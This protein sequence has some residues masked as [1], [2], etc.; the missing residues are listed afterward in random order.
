MKNLYV[1]IRIGNA[2]ALLKPLF[3]LLLIEILVFSIFALIP[4]GHDVYVYLLEEGFWTNGI[5]ILLLFVS[6]V[7]LSCSSGLGA[8]VILSLSKI[9][10]QYITENSTIQNKIDYGKARNWV[11]T[12]LWYFPYLSFLLGLYKA[13]GFQKEN[14][15][16][17]FGYTAIFLTLLFTGMGFWLIFRARK[18]IWTYVRERLARIHGTDGASELMKKFRGSENISLKDFRPLIIVLCVLL[19]FSVLLF[20][21]FAILPSNFYYFIGAAALVVFGL[22]AW[23]NLY[24]AVE[25]V[26]RLYKFRLF[27]INEKD[28]NLSAKNIIIVWVLLCSYINSDHPLN[29]TKDSPLKPTITL[30]SN[31]ERYQSRFYKYARF[32][33]LRRKI[34][35]VFVAVDGGASRTGLFGSMML[36]VLQDSIPDFKNH[37]FAYSDISGGTL[38]A[39]VFYALSRDGFATRVNSDTCFTEQSRRFFK[40]DFL[41]PVIGTYMF[42]DALGYFWPWYIPKFDRGLALEKEWQS[43][44]KDIMPFLDNKSDNK[45]ALSANKM[46][47]ISLANTTFKPVMFINSHEVE[48]GRRAI[49][50]NVK[51]DTT[52]FS[53]ISDLNDKLRTDLPFSSAILLSARFPLVSPSASIK[54]NDA[55]KR[56]YVDGGYFE[57]SGT[58]TLYEALQ[59][60]E[61]APG[62]DSTRFDVFVIHL[63]GGED[64]VEAEYKGINFLNE[65]LDILNAAIADRSGHTEF[66]VEHLKNYVTNRYGRPHFITLKVGGSLK[67]VPVNWVLS[68]GAINQVVSRC[69]EMLKKP[70]LSPVLS[71][72]S[73]STISQKYILQITK[74]STNQNK[75]P[76]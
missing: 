11:V 71:A 14:G 35:I 47:G 62:F 45:M 64:I 66:A 4:Q 8:E 17:G 51:L 20:I 15:V 5:P 43:A 29:T 70:E 12:F 54:I 13:I 41:A 32:D 7:F 61:R 55:M 48:T 40:R 53:G 24:T 75:A 58:L 76:Q 34:P 36:S 16:E 21:L 69:R 52:I 68:T 60:L 59:G 67:S 57:S 19:T 30:S 31:L 56:H 49:Y 33:T 37:I 10:W 42:G 74:P 65:P 2:I 6:L 72:I 22:G 9:S 63:D 3:W 28:Y 39:N 38:G 73:T 26:D 44:W 18:G 25:L 50:S 1:D 46:L 27:T 23:V